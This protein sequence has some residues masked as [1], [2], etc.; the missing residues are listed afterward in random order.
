M[1]KFKLEEG[2]STGLFLLGA[3]L[4]AGWVVAAAGWTDGLE[5][6]PRAGAGGVIA[7]LFLGWSVFRGRTSHL[8]STIY[9]LSWVGY[10]VGKE[11]PGELTWGER[12]AEM[13]TRL[14]YWIF[15]A[16]TGGTSND[17]LIFVIVFCAL[18]WVL[19][20]GAAWNTY[21]RMRVW[22]AIIPPGIVAF[23]NVYYY[24]GPVP[25][26]RYL[27]L[28]LFFA[29]LYVTR[30]HAF[31][32]ERKWR[33]E[34]VAYDPIFRFDFLRAGLI[35]S[36]VVLALAWAV[37][38]ATS[39]PYLTDAWHRLSDP[40]RTV[41]EEWKRLFSNL[42]GSA[43]AGAV[44][45]FGSSITLG[46]PREVRDVVVMDVAAPRKGRYYWRGAVY[47]YY[48]NNRWETVEEERI[49]LIPRRQPP[50]MTQDLLRRPVVQS[51]TNYMPGR[52]LLV[53]ASRPVAVDV[54]AEARINLAQNAPL[55]LIRIFST[56]PLEIGDKYAV[57]SQVSDADATSLRQAGA[58]YPD[59]VRERYLQLPASL[60]DRVRLL[61]REITL[62]AP[63]PYDKA[64]ALVQ[65]LRRN[66][67]YD[68]TPP[69]L[70]DGR[71][72]VDF[73]LF[74]SQRGYCNGYATAMVVM[75]RS[76]GIP[77]RLAAGYAEGEY[78]Q[79]RQVF[80]VREAN[81][82]SWPEIYFPAYGWI[83]FEP[84]ASERPLI[85]PE[86]SEEEDEDLRG[87]SW[88][89]DL[90]D[91]EMAGLV[92][93]LPE[94]DD[95]L[96]EL[97]A[98]PLGASRRPL[99]WLWVTGFL[100]IALIAGG[101][102]WA[103]ENWGLQGLSAI[104][105]AYARLLRFGHWLGCPLRAADTPFEW[106]RNLGT[107]VPEAREPLHRIVSLY[108]RA[109]FS[110]SGLRS[111]QSNAANAGAQ[112]AWEQARPILWRSW[113]KRVGRSVVETVAAVLPEPGL[114]RRWSRRI[115]APFAGR[116]EV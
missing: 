104:E 6:V 65:Y 45:P 11:L 59:W 109:R 64:I 114:W 8:F 74:D 103:A 24:F 112:T 32:Q 116:Y 96:E 101:G 21:R 89:E 16:V 35:L 4:A 69:S 62:G 52:N 57:T 115:A 105:Q 86:G 37:P 94:L 13:V 56:S 34:G 67:T 3:I 9:G 84:T 7:G 92:R 19:G 53:G 91:E 31:E 17:T 10:L 14:A 40:W 81:S 63:T 106:A 60:S 88:R 39:V 80:R 68:L 47:A 70:P 82:H 61:A 79:E 71:E 26:V 12:I 55:E 107:R 99:V 51:V 1:I 30:S 44:E 75:A 77:A 27:A 28:Y 49:P 90:L 76:L 20:Y 98:E 41:Q 113:F 43:V 111:A 72:Y 25:L 108:V 42:R 54:E 97:G 46:G 73:L 29:L 78:D 33:R 18:F 58:D 15:Q 23:L 38:T 50:G 66:I 5:V 48:D 83:E 87:E 100:V 2:W 22:H 95:S 93:N 85:R 102:W 110:R 36:I